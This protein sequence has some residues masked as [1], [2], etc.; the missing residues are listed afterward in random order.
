MCKHLHWNSA[1]ALVQCTCTGTVHLHWYS[2]RA[3]GSCTCSTGGLQR[4]RPV[5][6]KACCVCHAYSVGPRRS[7]V[8]TRVAR[9]GLSKRG[10]AASLDLPQR[11]ASL[12]GHISLPGS[13]SQQVCVCVCVCACVCMRRRDDSRCLCACVR[14]SV[15]TGV[16]TPG[17]C[18][19]VCVC[20]RASVGLHR[21]VDARCVQA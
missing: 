20:M 15:C 10:V 19:C 8:R 2:A 11:P 12:S 16:M 1:P 5:A 6:C 21:R 18:V 17:V 4:V 7:A 3:C 14:L 13:S 9:A